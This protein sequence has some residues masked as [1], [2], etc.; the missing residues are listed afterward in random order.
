L[1]FEEAFDF[2]LRVFG[3]ALE[4]W[5][6]PALELFQNLGTADDGAGI[7][8]DEACDEPAA[9]HPVEV[10]SLSL[11][12]SCVR[13]A[14]SGKALESTAAVSSWASPQ[15]ESIRSLS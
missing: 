7:I 14:A 3:G 11:G 4:R 6:V 8:G 15:L 1:G 12:C 13:N 9:G 2:P 5:E 10:H